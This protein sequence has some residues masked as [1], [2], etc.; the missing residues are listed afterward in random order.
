MSIYE[1]ELLAVVYTIQKWGTYLAH[2]LFVIRKDQKSIKYLLEQKLNT[3]LQQ[4]WMSKLMGFDFE[5]H[6]KERATNKPVDA[7]SRKPGAELLPLLL[8]NAQLGL[9]E[10]TKEIQQAYQNLQ[11]LISEL[12]NDP[13][14]HP[15]FTWNNGELRMK[16]KLV[17]GDS[18]EVK[19]LIWQ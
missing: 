1:R 15:K 2:K 3:P 18:S 4:V 14:S 7:L 13:K 11:T 19:L 16:G 10:F 12:Q 8:N 9:F 17:V 5:I 6:Y